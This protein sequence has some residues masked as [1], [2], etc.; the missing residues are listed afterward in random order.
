MN[1]YQFDPETG[2]YLGIKEA[3]KDEF[4]SQVKGSPCYKGQA[5]CVWESPNFAEGFTPYYIDGEWV[6]KPN[7]TSEEI[8]EKEISDAK[9]ERAEAVSKI[10]VE[11]DGML[12][13][14][15]EKAQERMNRATVTARE[16]NDLAVK[17]G[18]ETDSLAYLDY[19]TTW[20]LADNTVK[21]VKI[22][23]LARAKKLAG[24]MQ[25]SLWPIPYTG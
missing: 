2:R 15:D 3:V 7:P 25:T 1:L 23:Q 14:G 13:D 9:A 21:T 4:Q 19:E 20:I 22:N 11:V 18:T 6:N 17:S 8:A 24:D 12:F 10:V 5:N 16:M